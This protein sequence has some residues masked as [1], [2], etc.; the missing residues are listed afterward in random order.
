MQYSVVSRPT[1]GGRSHVSAKKV[2]VCFVHRD[3]RRR[4][5]CLALLVLRPQKK[6]VR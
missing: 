5:V 3:F 2:Q 1:A 6:T 4:W